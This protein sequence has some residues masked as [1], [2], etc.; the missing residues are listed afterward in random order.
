MVF[1]SYE[2]MQCLAQCDDCLRHMQ[3]LPAGNNNENKKANEM[4]SVG[5]TYPMYNNNELVFNVEYRSNKGLNN[6]SVESFL[7]YAD[8]YFLLEVKGVSYNF[9][10]YLTVGNGYA[11]DYQRYTLPIDVNISFTNV[12]VKQ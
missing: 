11:D 6:T 4:M 5:V 8:T 2:F 10:M 12:V 7:K 1:N 9:N 3:V